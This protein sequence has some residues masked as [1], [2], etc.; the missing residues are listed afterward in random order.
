MPSCLNTTRV[1]S[2][3][4]YLT[5]GHM[6]TCKGVAGSTSQGAEVERGLARGDSG[7]AVAKGGDDA[8]QDDE[9]GTVDEWLVLLERLDQVRRLEDVVVRLLLEAL[10]RANQ[11][12]RVLEQQVRRRLFAQPLVEQRVG[13]LDLARAVE[14]G[15]DDGRVLRQHLERHLLVRVALFEL[16]PQDE[17]LLLLTGLLC[18]ARLKGN[19][20]RKLLR[21]AALDQLGTRRIGAIGDRRA[22]RPWPAACTRRSEARR[23]CCGAPRKLRRRCATPGCY[24]DEQGGG[25]GWHMYSGRP[26]LTASPLEAP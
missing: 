20:L 12:A 4:R 6:R 26:V 15:Q 21:K 1:L 10:G 24:S 16:P 13:A 25:E 22:A 19:P 9:E 2:R 5:Y 14:G 8:E 17:D 3:L 7:N 11:H 23:G 18:A